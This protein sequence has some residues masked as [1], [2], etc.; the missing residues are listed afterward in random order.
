MKK[1]LFIFV[2]IIIVIAGYFLVS[3]NV[4]KLNAI[5]IDRPTYT[6]GHVTFQY[7]KTF[8]ANVRK[9]VTRPPTVT[10]VRA[11]QDPIALGCPTLKDSSMIT[12][13]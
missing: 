7:P 1:F 13:S 11:D 5:P 9:A 3:K 10:T 2:A 12:K 6:N 4:I 8:G